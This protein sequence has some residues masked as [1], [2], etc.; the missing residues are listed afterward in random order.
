M[1]IYIAGPMSHI[2][3]Q[4]REAFIVVADQLRTLGHD[5]V[6][7][8]EHADPEIVRMADRMGIEFRN[9]DEYKALIKEC[10]RRV[11]E[12]D[13]IFLLP[14]W[15]QSRGAVKEMRHAVRHM[16]MVFHTIE[17]VGG[18]VLKW[19]GPDDLGPSR[20]YVGDAGFDLYVA[21]DTRIPVDGFVDVD[22]G[23]SV[24]M[25]PGLWAMLTGR[26]STIRRRGLLVTQGIIDNG[27]RGPLYA[28]VQNLGGKVVE[29]ERGERIA[30]LIPFQQASTGITAY[31]V[32]ELTDS[33]RGGNGFGSTGT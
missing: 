20:T 25:P 12:C 32:A 10:L 31:R 11:E 7:P 29:L 22:L 13:A 23:I 14:G 3:D 9:T 5:P 33:D 1:K 15:G 2:P 26:S 16:K 19:T 27:Y 21:K 4:N 18:G 30:Q 28:G 6:N 8:I 24:E 17:Q